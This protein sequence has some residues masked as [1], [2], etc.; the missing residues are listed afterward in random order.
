MIDAHCHLDDPRFDADREAL[1]ERARALGVRAAVLAGTEPSQWERAAAL[2]DGRERFHAVG[3]HPWFLA[4][5]PEAQLRAALEALPER[6]RTLGAV[7]VG[8][9]GLDAGA[10]ARAVP[11]SKQREVLRAQLEAAR[12]LGLPVVLHVVKAHA[13][14]LAELDRTPLGPAG[15]LVH[16]YS[17]GPE[18][19]REW[20]ARGVHL[21]FGGA[22][23]RPGAR[24]A[25]E[26]LLRVP[27][28]RLLLE[29]DAP[30]QAPWGSAEDGWAA[31]CE[32]GHL[33]YTLRAAATL[34]GESEAALGQRTEANARALF[35]LP[36]G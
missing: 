30:S 29:T 11:L 36:R 19:V 18:L 8:E 32:P 2:C 10:G 21:S 35:R 1:W 15:G 23:T 34:R 20:L 9:C 26:A 3:L 33:L 12:A 17:G 31:R 13:E 5:L 6:A 4:G 28:E 27:E 25:A 22:L 14:A 7:A 16:A 24:R